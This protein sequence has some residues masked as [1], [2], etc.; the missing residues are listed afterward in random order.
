MKKV[1]IFFF[2][3]FSFY[4]E[5]YSQKGLEWMPLWERSI[6]DSVMNIYYYHN[7]FFIKDT[8]FLSQGF[9]MGC[10]NLH[11]TSKDGNFK[12]LFHIGSPFTI[13]DSIN[14]AGRTINTKYDG[15]ISWDRINKDHIQQAKEIMN[16]VFGKGYENNWIDYTKY[17]SDEDAFMKF[18]ADT[19]LY[20]SLPEQKYNEVI[21]TFKK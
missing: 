20:I 8:T 6:L 12:T 18:N 13:E 5:I 21:L 17:M 9:K 19:A 3:I 11:L 4:N 2:I 1:I 16:Q 10:H 7:D 15:V 14:Y